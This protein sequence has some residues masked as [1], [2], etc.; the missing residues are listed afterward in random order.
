MDCSKLRITHRLRMSEHDRLA[1]LK[2]FTRTYILHSNTNPY[3]A[4]AAAGMLSVRSQEAGPYFQLSNDFVPL[5]DLL[6]AE[7]AN[8]PADRIVAD[9]E[10]DWVMFLRTQ[11]LP[12][13]GLIYDEARSPQENTM[14][15]LNAYNRRIPTS[16]IPR[17]VHESRELLIPN[18][19]RLDYDALLLLIRTG[20]DL[21]PYLS[22][23]IL[24]KARSD[25]NDGLLNAWG[26]QH[27]HFRPEGTGELLFSIITDSDVFVIQALP[28]QA[29]HLWVNTQLFQIVH[30]NWPDL[31]ARGR[32]SGLLPEN[33]PAEKR[34]SLRSFHTN[35]PITVADGTVYIPPGG[36]TMASGDSQDDR[37]NCDKIFAELTFWQNMVTQNEFV[38]RAELN[39]PES[40]RLV[41]RMAFDNRVCCF[42]EATLG[43][44]VALNMPDTKGPV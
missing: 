24:K 14:R 22:R 17:R 6:P 13:C 3:A 36:G 7:D 12:A 44:R 29:E 9:F 16:S 21:K 19:Y 42:Y 30:E 1:A 4:A 35:F 33:I 15:F 37:L 10:N 8:G 28:H 40:R 39:L 20:G 2:G 31:I 32:H 38:I 23:D 11:G 43:V 18:D 41:M 25:R 5:V 27:L 34:S 26:I